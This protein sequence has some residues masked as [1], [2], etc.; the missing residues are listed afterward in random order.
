LRP[1]SLLVGALFLSAPT[2]LLGAPPDLASALLAVERARYSFTIGA[3]RPFEEVYTRASFEAR[4]RR[5]EDE[6]RVLRSRFG[7]EVTAAMEA[8]ECARVDRSTKAP[9]QWAAIEAALGSRSAVERF[10]CGPVLVGRLLRSSFALDAAIHSG[11]HEE[12]RAARKEL[13]AGGSPK[14]A[15][16]REL[17][18]PTGTGPAISAEK[19]LADAKAG[20]VEDRPS[21]NDSRRG[22]PEPVSAALAAILEKELV[23]PGDV[24]RIAEDLD[25]F[26]VFR[27]VRRTDEAWVVDGFEVSKLPFH[28]WLEEE[29]KSR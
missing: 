4:A 5:L 3:T 15:K 29:M 1:I 9:D 8:A 7:I 13:L 25:R 2:R 17:S 16:R 14:G 27:L 28:P 21:A 18:R 19:L 23:R 10:V 11:P 20:R 22:G 26:S 24:T 12:A 6:R